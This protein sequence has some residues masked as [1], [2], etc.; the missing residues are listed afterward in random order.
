MAGLF[1]KVMMIYLCIGVVLFAASSATNGARVIGENDNSV[2]VTH[3][4]K[5]NGGGSITY[6]QNLSN[7]IPTTFQSTGGGLLN[8]IDSLGAIGNFVFFLVN[9]LFWPLGMMASLGLS[10]EIVLFFG[11]PLM[12]AG[13]MGFAYFVRSGD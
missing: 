4:I 11:V 2:F 6:S 10:R 5:D 13:L 9:M 8:L 7:V 1:F 3:F 12:F